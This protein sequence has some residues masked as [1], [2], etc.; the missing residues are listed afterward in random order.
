MNSVD[1]VFGMFGSNSKVEKEGPNSDE[2]VNVAFGAARTPQYIITN[3]KNESM[4]TS[5]M[6]PPYK[7]YAPCL[8]F[9]LGSARL[10]TLDSSNHFTGDGRVVAKSALVCMKYGTWGPELHKYLVM[11]IRVDHMIIKRVVTLRGS[12]VEIQATQFTNCYITTYEQRGD[13][14][15]F[16]FSFEKIADAQIQYDN[17]GQRKTG[18]VGFEYDYTTVTETTL[19]H[20]PFMNEADNDM[21]DV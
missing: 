13:K 3:G 12:Y 16:T 6:A 1:R 8:W 11:G 2:S 20:A 21:T 9:E 10:N 4:F 19:D 5:E 18:A 17:T 14:I 15:Y 7:D